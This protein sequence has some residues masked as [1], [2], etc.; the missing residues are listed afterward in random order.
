MKIAQSSL[1]E[2]VMC[3]CEYLKAMNKDEAVKLIDGMRTRVIENVADEITCLH[4]WN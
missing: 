2:N 1:A 4:C 3:T